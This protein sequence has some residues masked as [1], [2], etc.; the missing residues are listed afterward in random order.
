MKPA[1]NILRTREATAVTHPAFLRNFETVP[2]LFRSSQ[3]DLL[4]WLADAHA[5]LGQADREEIRALLS[6]IRGS[7][8]HIVFRGHELPDFTH[9]AWDRMRLFGPNGSTLDEKMR[10]FDEAVTSAFERLYPAGSPAPE[11]LVHVTCTGY[12]APSGA[13][14]L[15]A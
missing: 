14:R 12:S 1:E 15:V 9:R 8:D 10:F 11:A 6:R 7:A 13:Q 5:A 4:D 2:P 3:A